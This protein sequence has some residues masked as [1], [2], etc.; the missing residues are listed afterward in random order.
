MTPIVGRGDGVHKE[1]GHKIWGAPFKSGR[2][3]I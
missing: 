3:D 2:N 1:I